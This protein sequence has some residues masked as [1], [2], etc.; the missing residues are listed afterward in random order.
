LAGTK[1][2]GKVRLLARVLV[3][4]MVMTNVLIMCL[5][6]HHWI[7]AIIGCKGLGLCHIPRILGRVS[8]Y[9]SMG[10]GVEPCPGFHWLWKGLPLVNIHDKG[11]GPCHGFQGPCEE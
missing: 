10:I 2:P 3:I 6:R 5:L 1:L 7:T 9:Q 8:T 4:T 11:T